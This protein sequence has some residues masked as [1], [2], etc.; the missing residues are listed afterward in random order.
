ML[1]WVGLFIERRD[2]IHHIYVYEWMQE[3]DVSFPARVP[4]LSQDT[5]VMTYSYICCVLQSKTDCND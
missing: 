4:R 5:S 1:C 2:D 3:G